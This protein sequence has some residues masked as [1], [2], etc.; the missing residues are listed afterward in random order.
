MS[1]ESLKKDEL[2]QA[3]DDFGVDVKPTTTKADIITAL[4][5]DGV[6]YEVWQKFQP[7]DEDEDAEPEAPA[8]PEVDVQTAKDAGS[9]DEEMVLVRMI[10][11][12]GTYEI[13]GYRFTSAHPYALVKESHADYLVE[14]DGGFRIASPKEARE[15][16]S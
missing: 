16:Y 13:Y 10:R 5:D 15:F 14:V 6:T 1:F 9:D 12:N 3:A 7:S 8:E 11:K 4:L 2:L